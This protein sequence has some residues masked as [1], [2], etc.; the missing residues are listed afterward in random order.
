MPEE[1][2]RNGLEKIKDKMIDHPA[3]ISVNEEGIWTI[4]LNKEYEYQ[5]HVLY[6]LQEIKKKILT[7]RAT[8]ALLNDEK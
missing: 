3:K 8:N 7:I 1:W 2:K 5:E 4:R 6:I